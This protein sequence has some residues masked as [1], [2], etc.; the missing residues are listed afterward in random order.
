MGPLIAVALSLLGAS[1]RPLAALPKEAESCL[2]CHRDPQVAPDPKIK[3]FDRSVHKDLDCTSCHADAASL[4][5]AAGLKTV[6]C[7]LCHGQEAADFSKS[8]HG[9]ALARGRREAPSCTDCHGSGHG[10]LT[11]KDKAASVSRGAITK[12]CSGC[13]GSE[14]I[15]SKFGLPTD[16]VQTFNDSFHGLAGSAGDLKVANCASCHGWHDVLPSSDPGS[17]VFSANIAQTCGKCH[18]GAGPRLT[19]GR[20]HVA[21]AGTGGGSRVAELFRMFY[22]F[23]IPLTIGGMLVHNGADLL[24]KVV[25][26]RRLPPLKQEEDPLLTVPERLQHAALIVSFF[27]LAWS[28][29]A[30]KFPESWWSAPLALLGGEEPRRTFHR[31]AALLFIIVGLL[32]VGYM[33]FDHKGRS[34]LRALLPARRDLDDPLRLFL[35]N[36][37]LSDE[38]PLL[39]RWSYIEKSEYWALV[40]GSGVMIATGTVLIFHNAALAALPLWVIET[41]RVIHYMEAILACLSILVWHLYWV[42]YDPDVYPMNWA[43]LTGRTHLHEPGKHDD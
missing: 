34:R 9:K 7:G 33:L 3:D 1:P 16:R 23:L 8:V 26:R 35:F 10:I 17:R 15:T 22:L 43:W 5:H 32:H 20:V 37:G 39:A 40:W 12:T 11:P 29:F 2:A 36:L 4:P 30:L 14:R 42:V 18:P 6:D 21:L 27:L 31:A 24:R 19:A 28:G 38:R 25:A 13:H 41:S